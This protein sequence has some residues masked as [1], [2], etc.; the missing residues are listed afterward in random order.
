[1][2]VL[3]DP[4]I[5]QVQ[6]DRRL[7]DD[8]GQFLALAGNSLVLPQYF[9][10]TG[11][12]YL[13]Q[14]GVYLFHSAK[15]L[16]EFDGGFTAD[17]GYARYVVRRVAHQ[18]LEV[19]D[20]FRLHAVLAA[21]RVF[22]V[23]HG[24][25]ET[26]ARSG[27]KDLNPGRDQ[28]HGV[29]IAGDDDGIDVLLAGL[30]AERAQQVIRLIVV[31]LENRNVE[32]LHHLPHPSDLVY[33]LYRGWWTVCLVLVE[34]LVPE[35]GRFFI[36][37]DGVMGGFKLADYLEQHLGKAVNRPDHFPGL[38]HRQG[39]QGMVGAVNQGIAVKENQPG[40]FHGL[41]ITES[42]LMG[43]TEAARLFAGLFQLRCPVAVA[44]VLVN[45]H[46]GSRQRGGQ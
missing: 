21:H 28:L 42:G 25:A 35:G 44:H 23:K 29:G 38:T 6:A 19:A 26:L 16:D 2:F 8:G 45:L 4:A 31:K 37:S 20:V 40:L 1:M 27:I 39:W 33:Q 10:D 7:D 5:V 3:A 30:V 32:G 13:T 15:L 18:S 17:T 46:T 43:Q 9:L 12:S 34:K 11:R 36:E 24:I 22:I 41:I 14:A